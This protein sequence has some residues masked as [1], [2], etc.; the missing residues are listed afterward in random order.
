MAGTSGLQHTGLGDKLNFHA[1]EDEFVQVLIQ[2]EITS[3][4]SAFSSDDAQK[5]W[6]IFVPLLTF[7]PLSTSI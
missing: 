5:T 1:I 3:N 2:E 4:W 7:L 6:G